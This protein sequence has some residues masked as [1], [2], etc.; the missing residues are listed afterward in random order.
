MVRAPTRIWRPSLRTTLVAAA[1]ALAT[2]AAPAGASARENTMTA[3]SAAACDAEAVKSLAPSGRLRAAINVGNQ[4][5]ASR[6]A[7]TGE[8]G[9]TSVLL[10]RELGRRLNVAVDL[11]PYDTAGKVFAALDDDGWDVAFLAA[12]QE[13]AAKVFFTSPYVYIEGT[14]L[15]RRDSPFQRV[16]DL[17]REGVRIAVE[18]NAA[19]ALYLAR[20]LKHA[21]L[22]SASGFGGTVA[23]LDEGLDAT[24]GVR[25]ALATAAQSRPDL[26]VLDSA[27][28]R[29]E[30]AMGTPRGREA[31]QPCLQ[32][33]IEEMK[34]NGFVRSA[35]DQTGQAGVAVAVAAS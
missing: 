5:L 33:F 4:V 6:D 29:I 9:G 19:Y 8:L 31:G 24:A 16:E 14:Y 30:Q 21:K 32:A 1:G 13:R 34:A 17:D 23:L 11:V 15:V 2:W 10:A 27:F 26:K 22:V 3:S 25:Q 7:A 28:Q 35:L 12:E 20:N 18:Q